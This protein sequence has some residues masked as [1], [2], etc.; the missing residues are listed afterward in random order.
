MLHLVSRLASCV[1]ARHATAFSRAAMRTLTGEGRKETP[2]TREAALAI[3][4]RYRRLS[5]GILREP[6]ESTTWT[7]A[8]GSY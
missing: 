7:R 8:R 1:A 6:R 5:A 4:S 3:P 2:V